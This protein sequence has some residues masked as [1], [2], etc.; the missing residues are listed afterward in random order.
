MG[1]FEKPKFLDPTKSVEENYEAFAKKLT[2]RVGDRFENSLWFGRMFS[3]ACSAI[4]VAYAL[5]AKDKPEKFTEMTMIEFCNPIIFNIN[6]RTLSIRYF[7]NEQAD[8]GLKKLLERPALFLASCGYNIN[9]ETNKDS[10][11]MFENSSIPLREFLLGKKS[12][13]LD[14]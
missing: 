1:K 12:K 9:A 6:F 7:S 2:E 3:F 11:K 5:Y 8:P 10:K 14:Q 4:S 13:F